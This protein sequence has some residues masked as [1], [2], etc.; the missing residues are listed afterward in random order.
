M[1]GFLNILSKLFGNKYDKDIKQITPI[2]NEINKQY[3]MLLNLTNDELRQK[4]INFKKQ[5]DDFVKEEKN[6]IQKLKEKATQKDINAENKEEIYKK[7]DALEQTIL[8]KIQDVLNIILP[9][10][11]AV[12][13]ETARRF[14][15]NESLKVKASNNDK[16]LASY[17]KWRDTI[18]Y[19]FMDSCSLE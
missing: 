9:K 1:A 18:L 6:E 2:V 19:I 4:T 13:K 16:E 15:E 3:E 14:T 12:V 17:C 10:A 7:I 11:F 8:E 5:I